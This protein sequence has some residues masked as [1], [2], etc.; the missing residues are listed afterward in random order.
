VVIV[1]AL[2]LL[3]I[4]RFKFEGMFSFFIKPPF[5]LRSHGYSRFNTKKRRV[6]HCR[7]IPELKMKM[8][9]PKSILLKIRIL[10][11]KSECN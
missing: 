6:Y 10:S 2:E 11:S 5:G 8:K 1:F 7:L 9:Y 4:I 3:V